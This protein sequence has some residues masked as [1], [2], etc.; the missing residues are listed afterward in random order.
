MLQKAWRQF[1]ISVFQCYI[2]QLPNNTLPCHNYFTD[3]DLQ[4]VW[5]KADMGETKAFCLHN[6]LSHH[7]LETPGRIVVLVRN[8]KKSVRPAKLSFCSQNHLLLYA[9]KSTS[10]NTAR[11]TVIGQELPLEEA[12]LQLGKSTPLAPQH[13]LF[14]RRRTIA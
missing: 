2:F 6:T 1:K 5:G 13:F 7:I 14:R 9:V 12:A 10:K 3:T 8:N 11:N 4:C